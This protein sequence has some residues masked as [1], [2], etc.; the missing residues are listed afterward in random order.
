MSA[1][2]VLPWSAISPILLLCDRPSKQAIHGA[3]SLALSSISRVGMQP[4]VGNHFQ[5]LEVAL[6]APQGSLCCRGIVD[7]DN[8]LHR[9][10]GMASRMG[11]GRLHAG[12]IFA[13]V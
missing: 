11:T 3:G 10:K 6:H 7:D 9:A 1:F 8:T 13:T 5:T 4:R 2:L 12:V